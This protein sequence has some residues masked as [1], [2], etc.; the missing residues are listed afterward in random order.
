MRAFPFQSG[1]WYLLLAVLLLSACGFHP[2]G[3]L[4]LPESLLRVRIEA[5]DPWGGIAAALRD[6]L[7]RVGAGSTQRPDPASAVLKI[8]DE[9]S[10][11][12]VLSVGSE[13]R[14]S[15]YELLEE[16]RFALYAPDGREL[17]APQTVRLTR[18]VVFDENRLLGKV[19]EREQLREQARRELA[20]RVI[21]RIRSQLAKHEPAAS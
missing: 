21:Y 8:L 9:R 15:E 16:V 19:A 13:G 2:R 11:W 14:A 5:P 17:V 3:G 7:D 4:G 20:R 10:G 18:D 6:A 1:Q 12:R